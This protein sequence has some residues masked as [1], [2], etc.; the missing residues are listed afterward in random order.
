MQ[1]KNEHECID[2]EN[3]CVRLAGMV[4]ILRFISADTS[5]DVMVDIELRDAVASRRSQPP[6]SFRVS[7]SFPSVLCYSAVF[8]KMDCRETTETGK[9]R[10]PDE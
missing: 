1:R 4:D 7:D 8:R 6:H 10:L 2:D 5:I 9:G 3:V